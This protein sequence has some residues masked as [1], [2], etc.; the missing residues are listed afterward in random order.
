MFPALL[1]CRNMAELNVDNPSFWFDDVL[2]ARDEDET[3]VDE[4]YETATDALGYAGSI[5]EG[6]SDTNQVEL[7]DDQPAFCDDQHG[8]VGTE[9][10]TMRPRAWLCVLILDQI[11]R[12][13]MRVLLLAACSCTGWGG[14]G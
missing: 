4:C 5:S 13:C 14:L 11:I 8:L 1:F 12:T 2:A 7:C 6:D 9:I 3:I 10:G